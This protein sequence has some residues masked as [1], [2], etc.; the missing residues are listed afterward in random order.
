MKDTGLLRYDESLYSQHIIDEV[1]KSDDMK[2]VFPEQNQLQIDIDDEVAFIHY[3]A[4]KDDLKRFY[5]LTNEEIHPSQFG[6]PKRH[7][8]LTLAEVVSPIERSLLQACLGSDRRREFFSLFRMANGDP[9]PTLF[10]EKK[11]EEK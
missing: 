10:V 11:E 1:A 8:T 2:I 9:H 5:T 3:L 4:M 6:L 7:I